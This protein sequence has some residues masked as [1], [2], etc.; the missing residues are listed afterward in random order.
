LTAA[1]GAIKESVGDTGRIRNDRATPTP[2]VSTSVLG[3]IT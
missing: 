1:V 2:R 3:V